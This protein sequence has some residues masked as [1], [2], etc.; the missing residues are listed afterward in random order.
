L[1]AGATLFIGVIWRD[2]VAAV[3]RERHLRTGRSL[4]QVV[5]RADVSLT[6]ARASA[7]S[8][9]S[10]DGL[11]LAQSL[12]ILERFPL[13]LDPVERT[14]FVVEALRRDFRTARVTWAS[15]FHSGARM[16]GHTSL[17]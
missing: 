7:A 4:A 15:R 17:C 11:T 14:H 13:V 6:A 16:A 12:Q 10:S 9:P 3:R 1:P 2:M 8:L 5:E